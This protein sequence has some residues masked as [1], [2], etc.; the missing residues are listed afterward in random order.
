MSGSRKLPVKPV[1]CGAGDGNHEQPART[2]AAPRCRVVAVEE[3]TFPVPRWVQGM[4]R[5]AAVPPGRLH[6]RAMTSFTEQLSVPQCLTLTVGRL[7]FYPV[8]NQ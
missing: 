4:L 3:P 6:P 8:E 2:R 1:N 7:V 5:S